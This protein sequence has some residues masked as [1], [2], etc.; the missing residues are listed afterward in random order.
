MAQAGWHSARD[1]AFTEALAA[2]K[3]HF[4]RCGNCHDYVCN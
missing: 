4:N 2:G 3:T 1:E